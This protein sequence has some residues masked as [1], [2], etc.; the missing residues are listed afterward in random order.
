MKA[1]ISKI[2]EQED[3]ES[4]YSLIKIMV[5]ISSKVEKRAKKLHIG[6]CEVRQDEP[7]EPQ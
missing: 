5:T 4:H 7:D 1:Y 3:E 6:E 2:E